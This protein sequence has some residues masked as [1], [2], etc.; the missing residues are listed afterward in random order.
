MYR[1]CT[2]KKHV[3]MSDFTPFYCMHIPYYLSIQKLI[4]IS[5]FNEA[6]HDKHGNYM[7]KCFQ[8]FI[9]FKNVIIE[10]DINTYSAKFTFK[11][12]IR[13]QIAFFSG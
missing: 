7:L 4:D 8:N 11:K 6:N 10:I 13:L 3:N 12:C 2:W 9:I 1:F 5:S